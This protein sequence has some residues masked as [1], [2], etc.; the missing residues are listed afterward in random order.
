M[1]YIVQKRGYRITWPLVALAAL[2]VSL[3]AVFAIT[4]PNV[5]GFELEGDLYSNS[6]FGAA[7]DDWAE[8]PGTTAGASL[9]P[10][11]DVSDTEGTGV[12][13]LDGTSTDGTE[14]PIDNPAEPGL[15]IC[16]RD[17]IKAETDVSGNSDDVFQ[18]GSSKENDFQDFDGDGQA[19]DPSVTPW[20]MVFGSVPPNKDDASYI[21][22]YFD[23]ENRGDILFADFERTNIL[24]TSHIDMEL[25]ALAPVAPGTT[26]EDFDPDL[27]TNTV[28]TVL[29]KAGNVNPCPVRTTNDALF[30]FELSNGGA[31]VDPKFY[32]WSPDITLGGT[33]TDWRNPSP[34][35]VSCAATKSIATAEY[36][37]RDVGCIVGAGDDIVTVANPGAISPAPWGSPQ[38]GGGTRDPIPQ[39][40][41]FEL[42]LDLAG[43]GIAPGCPG[44]AGVQIKSRASTGIPSQLKDK[45]FHSIPL[46]Q[47]GELQ[48][49]KVDSKDGEP[50]PGA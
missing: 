1:Q 50:L 3:S 22:L 21:Y 18:Q 13:V 41:N 38:A 46:N 36:P 6:N 10:P 19:D 23:L 17:L 37:W 31:V 9:L 39:F 15:A 35:S 11:C 25:N 12:F 34:T 16:I 47:C 20:T 32:L 40:G 14:C 7:D 45:A 42:A 5:A 8:C 49:N 44:F 28:G 30:T 24:G 2:L 4:A 33:V 29:C 26:D 27:D 43:L 48:I